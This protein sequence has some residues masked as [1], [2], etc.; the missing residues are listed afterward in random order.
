[1]KVDNLTFAYGE[2]TVFENASFSFETGVSLLIGPSGCGKTTLLK[3]LTG[4]LRAASSE[5]HPEPQNSLLVL[6]EDAL[7]PW[8]SGWQNM[9]YLLRKPIKTV[10]ERCAGLFPEALTTHFDQK[11]YE[12]SYGQRRTVEILRAVIY[13]PDLLCLDEPFNFLDSRRRVE[14]AEVLISKNSSSYTIVSTHEMSGFEGRRLRANRLSGFF[15]IQS[16]NIVKT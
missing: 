15:P 8:L 11:A 16:A 2:K 7:L 14:L 5:I 9:A 4:N 12:M 1:M 3:L 13:G 10:R 6:Q